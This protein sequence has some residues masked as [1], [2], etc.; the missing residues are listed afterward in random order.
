[1]AYA[2]IFNEKSD[3]GL[4]DEQEAQT[5]AKHP[6]TT[7]SAPDNGGSQEHEQL[8]AELRKRGK[9]AVAQRD[10]AIVERDEWQHR[11][12]G[13]EKSLHAKIVTPKTSRMANMKS[14][15]VL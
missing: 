4:S 15:S 5:E 11:A 2:F 10:Q 1:M 13:A 8:I 14:L 9:I 12:M 3:V 7:T 6:N